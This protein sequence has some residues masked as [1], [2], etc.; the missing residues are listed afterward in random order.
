MSQHNFYV[1]HLDGSIGMHG[2]FQTYKEAEKALYQIAH[3]RSIAKG[4][5][6]YEAVEGLEVAPMNQELVK[7]ITTPDWEFERKEKFEKM[8][9]KVDSQSSCLSLL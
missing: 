9:K 8:Q 6:F 1:K 2:T 5:D 7:I 4:I 3:E